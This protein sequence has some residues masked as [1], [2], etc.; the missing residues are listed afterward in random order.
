MRKDGSYTLITVTIV[1][2]RNQKKEVRW[3]EPT[4]IPATSV[5]LKKQPH[6]I[7]LNL[8][9]SNAKAKLP[10]ID[11]LE[12]RSWTNILDLCNILS[13]FSPIEELYSN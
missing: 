4:P 3:L 9:T 6:L 2:T 13:N 10:P 7:P 12:D 1:K 11:L 5:S 8:I